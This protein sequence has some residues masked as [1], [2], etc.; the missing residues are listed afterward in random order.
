MICV[1]GGSTQNCYKFYKV[2]KLMSLINQG[3]SKFLSSMDVLREL[4]ILPIGVRTEYK[5]LFMVFKCLHDLAPSYL[6]ELF[7]VRRCSYN[8]RVA[9]K[10]PVCHTIDT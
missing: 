4:H 7:S 10:K 3:R 6:N 5:I 8:T 9:G 2:P 1:C